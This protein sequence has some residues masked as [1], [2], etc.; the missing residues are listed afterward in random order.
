MAS[1]AEFGRP[2]RPSRPQDYN[3]IKSAA[4]DLF[5]DAVDFDAGQFSTGF[6]P[7]TPDGR[8]VIGFGAHSNLLYN[9]GHGHMGWTMSCGSGRIVA[10]LVASRR[11]QIE[12]SGFALRW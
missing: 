1:T 3:Q 9:T 7:M 2:T 6:R 10:D 4:A 5:P 11:P 12:L 8:P